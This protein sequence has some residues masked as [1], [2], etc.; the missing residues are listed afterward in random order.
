[1]DSEIFNKTQKH[2]QQHFK[3]ISHR[4]KME[5]IPGPKRLIWESVEIH[6]IKKWRVR[7]IWSSR[8]IQKTFF[9]GKNM[10]STSIQHGT[11]NLTQR[12][13]VHER[14]KWHQQLEGEELNCS[15]CIWCSRMKMYKDYITWL[16]SEH[17]GG[18]GREL[19]W[20]Q[21]QPDLHIENQAR[22]GYINPY[23][24]T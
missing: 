3:R 4:D 16:L 18:H 15:V 21:I 19:L 24:K 5:F 12:N 1:M 17:L 10:V 22:W 20:D 14:N 11:R 6:H 8:Y 23:L 9:S 7:P 2:I 13:W